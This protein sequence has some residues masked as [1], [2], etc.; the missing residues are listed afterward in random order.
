MKTQADSIDP[1]VAGELGKSLAPSGAG[2]RWLPNTDSLKDELHFVLWTSKTL[3]GLDG[4]LCLL[5]W[6]RSWENWD[7][8]PDCLALLQKRG[9]VATPADVGPHHG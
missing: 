9:P 3:I 2:G 8:C 4:E 7:R 6:R 1:A 5:A